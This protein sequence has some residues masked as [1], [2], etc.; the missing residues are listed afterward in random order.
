VS[1]PLHV[2]P[3]QLTLRDGARQRVDDRSGR[4]EMLAC[5]VLEAL[6]PPDRR[7]GCVRFPRD[8]REDRSLGDLEGV[9]Q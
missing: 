6:G 8:S 9:E 5:P 7:Q 4:G 3:A 1:G 2:A